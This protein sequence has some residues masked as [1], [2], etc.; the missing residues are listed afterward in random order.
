MLE[1][2][3]SD[4][5]SNP[6]RFVHTKTTYHETVME[7]VNEFIRFLKAI[8]ANEIVIKNGFLQA[9]Q[10]IDDSIKENYI[11]ASEE[12]EEET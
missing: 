3:F 9:I 11:M 6:E 12:E 2:I 4:N 7:T 5:N 10:D 1:F 8:G